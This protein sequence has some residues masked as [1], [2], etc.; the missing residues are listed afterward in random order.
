MLCEPCPT[1]KALLAALT[2]IGE[3]TV[4]GGG[5]AVNARDAASISPIPSALTC[6][7][8]DPATPELLVLSEVTFSAPESPAASAMEIGI[9][10]TGKVWRL[11]LSCIAA[12]KLAFGGTL[13][14][15]SVLNASV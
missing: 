13:A 3:V 8:S 14:G 2:E 7:A 9:P 4:A 10:G 5:V 15:G 11:S 12:E 6:S 1:L